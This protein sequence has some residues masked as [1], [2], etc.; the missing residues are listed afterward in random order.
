MKRAYLIDDAGI[1]GIEKHSA[2]HIT[3]F[4]LDTEIEDSGENLSVGERSLVSLA[5]ALVKDS[6]IVVLDE[7]TASVDLETDAKIQLTIERELADKTLLC[8][9]ECYSVRF[10]RIMLTILLSKR[11]VYGRFSHTTA[12]WY[13]SRVKFWSSTLR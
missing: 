2:E 13:W 12:F 11:T 3:R 10:L 5:R 8:I 9:G 1:E 6:R 4:N 7:A